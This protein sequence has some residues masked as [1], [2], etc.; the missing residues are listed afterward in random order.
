MTTR[1]DRGFTLVELLIAVA[2]LGL[3]IAM[4]LPG[5]REMK[6]RNQVKEG[7]PLAQVGMQGVVRVYQMTGKLPADNIVAGIPPSEKIVGTMVSDVRITN[8]AVTITYGN[9]AGQNLHGKKLTFRPAIV[10]EHRQVPIA[11]ICGRAP[12]PGGMQVQGQDETDLEPFAIPVECR[13]SG[14]SS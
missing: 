5:L 2:I 3:L 1:R 8:G 14:A 7:M 6:L 9:N 11:W 12:T 10:V 13:G 4:T